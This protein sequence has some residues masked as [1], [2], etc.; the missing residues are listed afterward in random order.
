[1][2]GTLKNIWF[3][4][5]VVV[6]SLYLVVLFGVRGNSD[7][8]ENAKIAKVAA[9]KGKKEPTP[10]APPKKIKTEKSKICFL[11]FGSLWS[12]TSYNNKISLK[13]HCRQYIDSTLMKN[14]IIINPAIKFR[15]S[16]SGYG[17]YYWINGDFKPATRYK[18]TILKGLRGENEE[19][20]KSEITR[21]TTTGNYN[22]EVHFKNDGIYL[23]SAGN[24]LLPI[25]T[26]NINHVKL[27]IHKLFPNN[28]IH[29][30][31]D[32]WEY[33]EL[34]SL[35]AE[36][37]LKIVAEANIEKKTMIDLKTLI[38]AEGS[39]IYIINA[40]GGSK[41][42]KYDSAQKTIMVSDLG[43]T[44]KRSA[45]DV[46][47]WVNRLS[48]GKAAKNALITLLNAANQ[49]I[50]TGKTDDDG[51]AHFKN[52]KFAPDHP[53]FAIIARKGEDTAI[54]E[55]EKGKID[56]TAF[57]VGGRKRET[58][59]CEAFI[60]TD[61]G[62]YRPG[63]N[64]HIKGIVR[65]TGA[66]LSLPGRF[67]LECTV[68]RSDGNI[69]KRTSV[70]LDENGNCEIELRIARTGRTG[71]YHISLSVP[72]ST[73]PLGKCSIQVEDFMPD[74]IKVDV[75]C[76][77]KVI[78]KGDKVVFKV[79]SRYYFGTPASGCATTAACR[80]IP[81]NF[82]PEN[83][84]D[85]KFSD[86]SSR[87]KVK[88]VKLGGMRLDAKG[89]AT[90]KLKIPT[91]IS[92]GSEM[93]AIFSATVKDPGG[94]AVTTFLVR[95]IRKAFSLGIKRMKEG[96]AEKG[97]VE[98]FKFMV[99]DADEKPVKHEERTELTA[100]LYSVKWNWAL[101][102]SDEGYR[103]ESSKEEILVSSKRGPFKGNEFF[104]TPESGGEYRVVIRDG[105]GA[106]SASCSFDCYAP[107]FSSFSK[108]K[109]DKI[110]IETDKKLYHFGDKVKLI[111]K[112]P[113]SGKGLLTIENDTIRENRV[114][115]VS[116]GS[117][118]LTFTAQKSFG[119][120]FYCSVSI[121]KRDK[122]EK[123][124]LGTHRG[125]T[126]CRAFG[127]I[128]VKIDPN[129]KKL[130]IETDIP[131]KLSPGKATRFAI[132]V[133][134]S[135]GNPR[136]STLSLALVD[137]GILAL[138]GFETPSPLDFFYARRG[139]GVETSDIYSMLMPEYSNG[140]V[141]NI[142]SPGGGARL[143][144][145]HLSRIDTERVKSA[146]IWK[147]DLETDDN[148]K[149]S[150]N[151]TIPEFAGSLRAMIVASSKNMF[152][153]H[154]QN[155]KVAAPLMI[156]PT[157][158]RFLAPG[159]KIQIPVTVFNK[160]GNAIIANLSFQ[161]E[162]TSTSVEKG[163]INARKNKVALRIADKKKGT[164]SFSF[165]TPNTPGVAS[166]DISASSDS[167][168]A[169]KR[170]KIPIRPGAPF[171]THSDSSILK[172][173]AKREK[174]EISFAIPGQWMPGTS[175]TRLIVS[176]SPWSQIANVV[177][178][179][180]DYPYGCLEQTTSK[181]FPLLNLANLAEK[182]ESHLPTREEIEYYVDSGIERIV[183]MQTV[184]G[185]FSMWPGCT[186]SY[187]WGTM[188]ATHFLIEAEKSGRKVQKET[189]NRAFKYISRFLAKR[190]NSSK[191][192]LAIK[193]YAVYVLALAG[194]PS[195]SW[196][197]R[198]KEK[199]R[200]LPFY[201]RVH[202]ALAMVLMNDDKSAL[203]LINVPMPVDS[204]KRDG[205]TTLHSYIREA[206]IILAATVEVAPEHE[207]IPYLAAI[208]H[209]ALRNPEKFSTQEQALSLMAIGKYLN[210]QGS[211]IDTLALSVYADGEKIGEIPQGA[212]S[213][214]INRNLSGKTITIS[215]TG[216]GTLYYSWTAKGVPSSGSRIQEL[217]AGIKIRR[218][219][220]LQ[221]GKPADLTNIPHGEIIIAEITAK[222]ERGLQNV[223][224]SDLL[225][226]GL[227]IENPKLSTRQKIECENNNPMTPDHIE[228]R[229]DRLLLFTTLNSG[230]SIYKYALRAVTRGNF[231]LPP[232][233]AECMY[234]P[235]TKSVNGAGR[236]VVK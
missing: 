160:T 91:N 35:F 148:G 53:P 144:S 131:K 123:G 150:V 145:K 89:N 178:A 8:G 180:I 31:R 58:G 101:K 217:D 30:L 233:S 128:P 4:G 104:F 124:Q 189:L 226:A 214:Q 2:N 182:K 61:R 68:R 210:H 219:Y 54:L 88:T 6:S 92:F 117:K 175:E 203:N 191:E 118:E 113:I 102:K 140:A 10:P 32:H 157:C 26:M 100:E 179:L 28:I 108:E 171:T 98:K 167:H 16:R 166:I 213:L 87:N 114:F 7:V 224:I 216:T 37:E 95:K 193:S 168:K 201:S 152:G 22:P 227:E 225:P 234:D 120:S 112:S 199:K 223:V 235:R 59:E 196:C 29:Y 36:K 78:Q 229:D 39:G 126:P 41:S 142:S 20:L 94:R 25:E 103:Y 34:S 132:M 81:S 207:N 231:A 62:V 185:G 3:W 200:A 57:N 38:G 18:I 141:E 66:K 63:E 19:V 40:L 188:Y 55:M 146:V 181:A 48:N 71:R 138:T 151:V 83:F 12:R 109:P 158:P 220:F 116:S 33:K 42:R 169:A 232:V 122:S 174:R 215:T 93:K 67:P 173:D 154:Q 170:F 86:S 11:K 147:G 236:L 1:M 77:E 176:R 73:T 82:R 107:W 172:C 5:F 50:A 17:G 187:P 230:I 72:G 9:I 202:L 65:K 15:V 139:L 159:D 164:A 163:L 130:F 14:K 24:M 105:R 27:T 79:K 127:I 133:K 90:F 209:D 96:Y 211:P 183:S 43:I 143:L 137:N 197:L 162:T 69:Y 119:R 135:G 121:I 13:L 49:T 155:I 205:K 177:K 206:A 192:T 70:E 136:K 218:R 198:L 85:Y 129:D 47:I 204:G 228:R 134:D 194:K 212:K 21:I 84:K 208:V 149:V 44:A 115:E 52:T 184:S 110:E 23:A 46:L 74:K 56:L 60:F 165:E 153:N 222:C 186:K 125:V 75:K 190:G 99:V 76:A 221:N 156:K 97:S 80:F 51:I 195:R 64:V 45:N 161:C 106:S 111:I